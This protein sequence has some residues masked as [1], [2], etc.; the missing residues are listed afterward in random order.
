[1][2][3]RMA[4]KLEWLKDLQSVVLEAI[5]QAEL[6]L[7]LLSGDGN[8]HLRDATEAW[9]EQ[10]RTFAAKLRRRIALENQNAP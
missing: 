7:H 6:G 9:V 10:Q 5:D 1:M 2:E 8:E 3:N 4:S